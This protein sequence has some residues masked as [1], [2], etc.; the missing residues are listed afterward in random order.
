MGYKVIRPFKDLND[1]E[2]HDYVAGDV[3]PREGH[4]PSENFTK[5]LLTGNNSAG[6]IFLIVGDDTKETETLVE[7]ETGTEEVPE[8]ADEE[9][10]VEEA[11]KP[12]R[13]R[14]TKKAEA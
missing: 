12:K 14:T 6:S 1:P 2:K 13:K 11:E 9:T 8:S 3:F 5:G 7:E 4:E 10:P